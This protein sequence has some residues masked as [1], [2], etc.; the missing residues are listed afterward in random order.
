MAPTKEL[1]TAQ[2]RKQFISGAVG[3]GGW[4]REELWDG[5]RAIN[6]QLVKRATDLLL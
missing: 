3:V 1:P 4:G 2:S 6:L 5:E